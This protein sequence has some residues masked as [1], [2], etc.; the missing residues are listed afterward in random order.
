MFGF[1]STSPL[2]PDSPVVIESAMLKRTLD[3]LENH[4]GVPVAVD[5]LARLPGLKRRCVQECLAV[6]SVF[7]ICQKR[8]TRSFQWYGRHQASCAIA[9][10]RDEVIRDARMR[11]LREIFDCSN[12]P[13]LPHLATALVKLH[14]YLGAKFL[15]LRKVS[16][17]FC[18]GILKYKTMLRKLYTVTSILALIAVHRRTAS[19]SEV[20][21]TYPLRPVVDS[22]LSLEILLNTQAELEEGQICERRRREFEEICAA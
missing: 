10:L 17:L 7:G 9:Q 6:C 12:D 21:F 8:S 15:D 1:Y 16:R 4:L 3:Q 13:S 5:D 2:C 14:I 22:G 20:Q 18:R 19:P 11:S